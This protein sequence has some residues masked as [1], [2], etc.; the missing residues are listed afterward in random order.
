MLPDGAEVINEQ[1]SVYILKSRIEPVIDDLW[2]DFES[3]DV[4]AS[5]IDENMNMIDAFED[6]LKA[7]MKWTE[8]YSINKNIND[9]NKFKLYLE[10]EYNK[11]PEDIKKNGVLLREKLIEIVN[12]LTSKSLKL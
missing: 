1:D 7:V 11:L 8:V 9:K 2:N 10:E 3:R 6:P 5:F 4:N 12:N